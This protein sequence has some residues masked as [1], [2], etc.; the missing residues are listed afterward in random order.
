[1]RIDDFY[2]VNR[3]GTENLVRVARKAGLSRFLYCSSQ[4]AAG[5]ATGSDPRTA[6]DPPTP[7]TDYGKSKLAGEEAVKLAAGDMWWCII[8]PP[9]VYGPLDLSFLPYIRGIKA[10]VKL[11][12]GK[13]MKFSLI[14]VSDLARALILALENRQSSGAIWFVTDGE[15]HTDLEIA[16]VV[17]QA[18]NKHAL[19]VNIPLWIAY[20]AAGIN[21]LLG[22]IRAT[23]AFF[24]WQKVS[25]LSSPNY[26][27]D[28]RSFRRLTGFK[29]E[30]DVRTGFK[31]T[32]DWYRSHGWL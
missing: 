5:P 4:A 17:E 27:C 22:K 32:V 26:T 20:G 12:I 23:P 11:R 15:A 2:R 16:E 30:L 21:E 14:Y 8:R 29:S 9:A 13:G 19:A 24:S 31:L 6:L 3:D 28:D 1:M 10:G 18:L 7:I 25:E